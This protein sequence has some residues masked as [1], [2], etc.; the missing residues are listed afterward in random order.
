MSNRP[1]IKYG[2]GIRKKAAEMFEQGHGSNAVA[3]ALNIPP[4]TVAKWQLRYRVMGK[5]GVIYPSMKY[6][7]Y[8]FETKLAAVKAVVD[9]GYSKAE[10]IEKFGILS[11]SI[12]D[13][14]CKS[15][16]EN[17]EESLKPKPRGRTSG[18]K[19]KKKPKTREEEL[20]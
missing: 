20:E 14:W 1:R 16:R 18:S 2:T 11:S 17:G 7:E 19:T 12:L 15:Y 9:E 8:S 6:K 5:D 4:S 13:K 3:S 10:T